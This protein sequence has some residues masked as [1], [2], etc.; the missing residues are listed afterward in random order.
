MN[1]TRVLA[2][3]NRKILEAYSR[4]TIAAL[5][6]ILP[7]RLALPRLE[8][9]L[10][11]N[12]AKEA[13]KDALVISRV[14][15]ALAA[16]L[17][18]GEEMVRQLLAAGK[19]V[20]RAFLDRV[21]DFP[22]GIV[23]R[24]EEIDPLR[25]QRIGRMQQAA[26][27]IL[28]RTGGRGDV[29]SA[30]RGCYRCGEFEQLLLDLMRLYAQETRALSRSLRLPA[31]LVPLRER[32]AQSLYDVMVDAAAGLASDVAGSVYRPRRVR[33]SDEPSG[34]PALGLEER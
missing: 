12:V 24:Y 7:L 8:S 19:E 9:F 21:S 3:W 30:I 1:S 18:P 15:E 14:G 11:D 2:A 20:D 34:E 23:I 27:L 25:L 29:R 26:R 16:G 33:R 17:T 4:C 5:R 28:A 13:A 31:L 22:I 10:A 6:A 32:I